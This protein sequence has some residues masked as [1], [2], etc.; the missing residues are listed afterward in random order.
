MG[1][2]GSGIDEPRSSLSLSVVV[3]GRGRLRLTLRWWRGQAL[4]LIGGR[5][6]SAAALPVRYNGVGC[7]DSSGLIVH[8]ASI[9]TFGPVRG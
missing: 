2:K 6:V 7:I 9:A 8:H 3:K 5:L 4:F 1:K